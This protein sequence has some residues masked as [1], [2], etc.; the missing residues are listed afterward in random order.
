[1]F[2]VHVS[3]GLKQNSLTNSWVWPK[4]WYF[5]E[6]IRGVLLLLLLLLLVRGPKMP[7]AR[8]RE[9]EKGPGARPRG[10]QRCQGPGPEGPRDARG[11]AQRG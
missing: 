4:L 8:L 10:A 9:A 5:L 3:L 1:M 11:Q 2:V 6:Y 7:G